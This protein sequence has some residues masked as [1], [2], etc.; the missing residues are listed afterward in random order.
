MRS[1]VFPIWDSKVYG[2]VFEQKPHPYRVNDISNFREFVRRVEAIR[3]EKR[4]GEFH[5]SVIRK[6]G[7]AVS[8]PRAVELVMFLN[9]LS[10]DG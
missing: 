4:F 8:E 6:V 7:Y 9:A 3:R 5:A 10:F 2:F 1:D